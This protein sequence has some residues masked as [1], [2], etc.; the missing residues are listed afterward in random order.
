ML[1][2]NCRS[3]C[4]NGVIRLDIV[5]YDLNHSAGFDRAPINSMCETPSRWTAVISRT[6]PKTDD[7]EPTPEVYCC[8]RACEPIHGLEECHQQR[9]ATTPLLKAPKHSG[10]QPS[11]IHPKPPDGNHNPQ[12]KTPD[13]SMPFPSVSRVGAHSLSHIR[14]TVTHRAQGRR[15]HSQ[16][17]CQ[18][19]GNKEVAKR[20]DQETC[21]MNQRGATE[22]LST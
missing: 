17:C 13:P 2:Y 3:I 18:A 19:E 5:I 1:I 14:H 10:A 12:C 21:G 22:G 20:P 15:T 16:D 4:V 8:V 6:A 7:H 9:C 11:S